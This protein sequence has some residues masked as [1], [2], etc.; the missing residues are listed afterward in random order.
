MSGRHVSIQTGIY[1]DPDLDGWGLEAMHL[2]TYLLLNDHSNGLT[3]TGTVSKRIMAAESRLTLDQIEK[4]KIEIGDKVKWFEKHT[5]WVVGRAKR[6]GFTD[7]GS[8]HKNYVNGII[9]DIRAQC[10]ELKKA[11]HKRYPML[12]TW[13]HDSIGI[14]SG[15]DDDGI[16]HHHNHN[17]SLN[18]IL[19]HSLIKDQPPKPPKNKGGSGGHKYARKDLSGFDAKPKE[20]KHRIFLAWEVARSGLVIKKSFTALLS[21][22]VK[23]NETPWKDS[24]L[25]RKEVADCRVPET[26]SYTAYQKQNDILLVWRR[27][28]AEDKAARLKAEKATAPGMSDDTATTYAIAKLKQEV[29]CG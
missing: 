28:P 18:H 8:V 17:Q 21:D 16:L 4:A 24:D 25:F 3:G 2:Y 13:Y 14:P 12:S 10:A 19:N 6:T 1:S 27:L 26:K 5:Y 23:R 20:E 7:D 11:F 29:L 15:H 9:K 22:R